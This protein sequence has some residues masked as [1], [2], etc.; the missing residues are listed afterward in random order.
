[1]ALV[2]RRKLHEA[3]VDEGWHEAVIT[4][5]KAVYGVTTRYGVVDQAHLTFTVGAVDLKLR[6]NLSLSPRSRLFSVITAV[7]GKEPGAEF[8][9][10]TLIGLECKVLVSHRKSEAGDVWERIERV[11]GVAS[12]SGGGQ[13]LPF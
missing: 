1:M 2:V 6:C 13:A 7:T 3:R 5:V 4:D 8:D 11:R 9:L 12:A 10:E